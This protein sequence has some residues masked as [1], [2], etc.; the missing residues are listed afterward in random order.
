MLEDCV[1]D[2]DRAAGRAH[3]TGESDGHVQHFEVATFI[4]LRE[5]VI[6]D[7]TEVW[8]DVEEVAPIGT[9]PM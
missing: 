5:G 6:G 3:V 1:S 8:T 7:M 9:R 2:G 4:T